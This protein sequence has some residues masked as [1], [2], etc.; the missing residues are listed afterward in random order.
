MYQQIHWA[1]FNQSLSVQLC[2]QKRCFLLRKKDHWH[3]LSQKKLHV[4]LVRSKRLNCRDEAPSSFRN[5]KQKTQN[6]KVFWASVW[7]DES[8]LGEFGCRG[9]DLQHFFP[10][11]QQKDSLCV[12]KKRVVSNHCLIFNLSSWFVSMLEAA[13]LAKQKSQMAKSIPISSTLA[14]GSKVFWKHSRCVHPKVH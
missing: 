2:I 6:R 7:I 11:S 5:N 4:Q 8:I 9:N 1:T 14:E 10:F 3:L 12:E 13:M